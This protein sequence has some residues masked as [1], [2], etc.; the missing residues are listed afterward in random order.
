MG[1]LAGASAA[2]AGDGT[3]CGIAARSPLPASPST[4]A[5]PTRT[6][7]RHGVARRRLLTTP[8][9][10]YGRVFAGGVR[11]RAALECAEQTDVTL[12]FE[13]SSKAGRAGHGDLRP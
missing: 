10:E 13:P 2:S 8:R 9:R 4:G 1:T 5:I 11:S 6:S 3:R 7:P 12:R